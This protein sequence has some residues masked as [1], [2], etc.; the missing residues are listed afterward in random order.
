MRFVTE[1]F[2]LA[3]I[4]SVYLALCGYAPDIANFRRKVLATPDFVRPAADAARTGGRPAE[5]YTRG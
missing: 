1:P 3:D 5:L 4:H 2:S